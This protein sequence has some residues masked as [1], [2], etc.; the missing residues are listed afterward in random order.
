MRKVNYPIRQVFGRGFLFKPIGLCSRKEI[1]IYQAYYNM[2]Y[3][4]TNKDIDVRSER[5]RRRHDARLF[6]SY[7]K[8]RIKNKKGEFYSQK[9]FQ[10][11]VCK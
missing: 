7:L 10:D 3:E 5:R 9:I 1:N 11:Q 2:K 8:R 6:H 4:G